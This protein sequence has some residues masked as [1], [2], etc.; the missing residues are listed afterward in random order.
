M[1]DL[2]TEFDA[3]SALY[4]HRERRGLL[5]MDQRRTGSMPPDYQAIDSRGVGT[6]VFCMTGDQLGNFLEGMESHGG[7]RN[8]SGI[9]TSPPMVAADRFACASVCRIRH[10]SRGIDPTDA[11]VSVTLFPRRQFSI[12]SLHVTP[13]LREGASLPCLGHSP[14]ARPD[15]EVPVR[16]GAP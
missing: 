16:A 4:H 12:V 15:G 10:N 8:R 9:C 11:S 5:T 7:Q 13:G 14:R 1:L 3:H 6:F 2:S